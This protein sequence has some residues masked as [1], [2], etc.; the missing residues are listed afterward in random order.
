MK[1]L[2][3]V[4]IAVVFGAASIGAVQAQSFEEQPKEFPPASYKGKQYVDSAGCVF[5]RAGIDGNVT[6]VPR[7]TR[8]RAGV[9]GFK[10]TNAGTALASPAP[11]ANAPV[12][13]TLNDAPTQTVPAAV[14]PRPV[15]QIRRTPPVVRQTAPAVVRQTAPRPVVAA[16][17]AP[18]GRRSVCPERSALAQ[19]YM[20]RSGLAE[21]CG[22]QTEPIAQVAR[23]ATSHRKIPAGTV[24]VTP[25]TRIVPKHVAVNRINTYNTV[26]VPEGYKPVWED[27]RLNPKR[28]EQNLAG[29]A[30]M[31]LMWT[32][33]V[34]RRLI[35]QTTG[36]DV[37]AR[38]PLIYPY[39]SIDQQ[40]R[41]MGHVTLSTRGGQVVKRVVRNRGAAPAVRT[42]TYSSRSAAKP[43][44]ASAQI[45]NGGSTYVQVG[46]FQDAANAQRAAKRIAGMGMGA[47]I[48]KSTRGGKTYL[49]VQAGPFAK[50]SAPHALGKLRGGGYQDAYIR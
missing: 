13:I 36:Q 18:Q 2:N 15:P 38:M 21:R 16:S 31:L 8:K 25:T 32:N 40:S 46:V 19:R 50:A 30:Q 41:E 1:F 4:A 27:D 20:G 6:W 3:I 47:R 10:P 33:T 26:Q 48:G 12:Q 49:S 43:D 29:R 37:T 35:N 11:Q 14:K 45:R 5:I 7:V 34:P 42:P 22:P 17:V 9:C 23:R 39:T 24:A 44:T 28:A